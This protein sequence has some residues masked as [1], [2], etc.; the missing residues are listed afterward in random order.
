MKNYFS[1]ELKTLVYECEELISASATNA[2]DMEITGN[3]D[4]VGAI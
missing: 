3:P 4:E 2:G 1:P